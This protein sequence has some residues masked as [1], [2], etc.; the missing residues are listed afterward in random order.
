MSVTIFQ[1]E[2]IDHIYKTEKQNFK[3]DNSLLILSSKYGITWIK[4]KPE[5]VVFLVHIK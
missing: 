5:L 4:Q 2:S 3:K 1:N